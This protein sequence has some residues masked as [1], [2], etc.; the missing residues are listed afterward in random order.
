MPVRFRPERL[1]DAYLL[2]QILAESLSAEE[3]NEAPPDFARAHVTP[4]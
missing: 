4:D 1:V 2:L 3:K